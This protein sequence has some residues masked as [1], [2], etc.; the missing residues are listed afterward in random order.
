MKTILML[1]LLMSSCFALSYQSFV[2]LSLEEKM[3]LQ[4]EGLKRIENGSASSQ[5]LTSSEATTV[6]QQWFTPMIQAFSSRYPTEYNKAVSNVKGYM[7]SMTNAVTQVNQSETKFIKVGDVYVSETICKASPKLCEIAPEPVKNQTVVKPANKRTAAQCSA[8]RQ[9]DWEVYCWQNAMII[10]CDAVS[11]A[12]KNM[13][14]DNLA[15]GYYSN[16]AICLRGG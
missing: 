8:A 5:Y 7:E 1:A 3:L 16:Q 14:L 4:N 10:S 2:S 9:K 6:K 11:D 13:V 12:N 15:K